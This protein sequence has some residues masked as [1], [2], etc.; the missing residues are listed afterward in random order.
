MVSQKVADFWLIE[1]FLQSD[2]L[3]TRSFIAEEA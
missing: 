2:T 1:G 3:A